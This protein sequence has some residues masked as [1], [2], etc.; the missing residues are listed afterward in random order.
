MS[1]VPD[2]RFG[3][4]ILDETCLFARRNGQTIKFTR[5]ERALL[6]ALTRNPHRLMRRA[7]LLDEIASESDISDRNI[8]FLVNRLRTKLG[9]SAKSPRYIATQYGEGY[10]WIAAPSPAA[11]IDAFLVIGASLAQQAHPFSQQTSSLLAQLGDMIS[12]GVGGGRK[13]VVAE[14]WSAGA[15]DKL[16]YLLQMSFLAGNDHLDCA[17]T[18]RE[19]PSKR[20]AKAFRL[21]LDMTDAAS[22]TAELG[23][24]ANG[25]VGILSQG[26]IDAS[27]GL[28]IP[29]DEPLETRLHKASSLLSASNRGWLASGERLERAREEDPLNADIALQWCLHLFARLVHTS[30]FGVISLEERYRIESEIDATVLECL[31]AIEANP[32]L[33]LTAAKLLYFI[34]RGHLDLSEDIAERAFART[35]DFAAALP[36]LGQLRYARGRFDEAVGFFDRGI[37]IATPDSNLHLHMRVLKSIAVLAS[38]D[39]ASLDTAV[40]DAARESPHCPRDIGLTIGWMVASPV[41]ALPAASADA[42]AAISSAGASNAIEYLYFTSARHLVSEQ[43]R[44]NVMRGLITHARRLHGEQAIPAFVLR[45]IGSIVAA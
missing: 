25:I 37:A 15:T 42:L 14:N 21:R 38:G 18:L 20:I 35:A 36:I 40:A 6:L 9:D 3:D 41:Q 10:V 5:N 19:M 26:L 32:L 24:V 34:D 4:L 33:M 45:S 23:R 39:R 16:R 13:V 29:E 27:T 11:P 2:L 17:A 43:A 1:K 30:P 8:D 28:G 22:S 44:A 12:V 31:P 7:R